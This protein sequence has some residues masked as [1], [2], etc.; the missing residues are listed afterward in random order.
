MEKNILNGYIGFKGEQGLSAYDI[1]VA[2]GFEGTEQD[3]LANLGTSSIFDQYKSIVNTT[4]ETTIIDA[5]KEY[6]NTAFIEI[7]ENGL[8]LN[9]NQYSITVSE[10]DEKYQISFTPAIASGKTLEIVTTQMTTNNLPIVDTIDE[11]STNDTAPG[12]KVVYEKLKDL[13]DSISPLQTIIDTI[14]PVGSVYISTNNLSPNVIFGGKWQQ[15]KNAFLLGAGDNYTI[16]TTGG[17]ASHKLTVNEMPSHNH[18]SKSLTGYANFRDITDSEDHNTVMG[19]SGIF[20]KTFEDWSG[21]HAGL[22][23]ENMSGYK[24]NQLKINAT[25]THNSEGGNIAHNNMPPYL[26]VSIWERVE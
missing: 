17:E 6:T 26:V 23:L 8:R 1:A 13:S 5:P 21:K 7:F 24:I 14:Y 18:G 20:S 2:N 15:I 25:H 3:W 10:D 12:T 16:G 22:K 4:G 19:T 9:K 11:T